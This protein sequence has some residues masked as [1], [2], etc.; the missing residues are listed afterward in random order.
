[1]NNRWAF[2]NNPP[3]GSSDFLSWKFEVRI[4]HIFTFNHFR[5]KKICSSRLLTYEFVTKFVWWLHRGLERTNA[6]QFEEFCFLWQFFLLSNYM[7]FGGGF[8]EEL[9]GDIRILEAA[10]LNETR[11]SIQICATA[12]S[13][14]TTS[15]DF[16]R[17]SVWTFL[18]KILLDNYPYIPSIFLHELLSG[19]SY[20]DF[21]WDL[22]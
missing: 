5:R 15:G 6:K 4:R 12:F 20:R 17:R 21:I 19:D 1:M 22:H 9:I 8:R 16:S 14:R 3:F 11:Y 18:H 10:I 7:K 13:V 2:Q